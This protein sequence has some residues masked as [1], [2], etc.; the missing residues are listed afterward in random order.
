M[1]RSLRKG[2]V[3]SFK[4]L[5]LISKCPANKVATTKIK[6]KNRSLDILPEFVNF[7]F[8]VYNGK[9]FVEVKVTESM[10]GHKLG[11]FSPTRT[12]KGHKNTKA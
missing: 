2:P 1:P 5:S 9:M 12:F 6:V 3:V 4:I 10:I 8:L 7:T 11:E